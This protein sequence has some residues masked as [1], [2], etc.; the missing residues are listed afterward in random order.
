[1]CCVYIELELNLIRMLRTFAII[2]RFM[3]LSI[4]RHLAI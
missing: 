4:L 3:V 1:M 2:K